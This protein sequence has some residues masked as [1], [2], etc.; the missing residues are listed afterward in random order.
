MEPTHNVVGLTYADEDDYE[1]LRSEV[2]HKVEDVPEN[3]N[4]HPR[5]RKIKQRK[6][7]KEYGSGMI[8]RR[9][10]EYY[11]PSMEG[12][13]YKTAVNNLF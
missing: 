7:N 13:L 2:V 9:R 12:K 10:P 11:V 8:M 4:N 1:D 3:E 5:M 6:P